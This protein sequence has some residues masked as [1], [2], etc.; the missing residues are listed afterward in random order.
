MYGGHITDNW[1]RRTNETY[2]KVLIR[3]EIMQNM[4]FIP[5]FA[6]RSP[7][8]NKTTYEHY[9]LYIEEKLPVESPVAF[10]L[11]PNAEIGYLTD[12]CNTIFQTIIEVQGGGGGGGSSKGDS[13]FETLM[14]LKNRVSP[15]FNM[16]EL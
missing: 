5:G 11:H 12:Q 10:G 3:P 1:D 6:Y 7:D 13:S 16:L 9:R 2:L 8:P 15:D 4:N 14:D